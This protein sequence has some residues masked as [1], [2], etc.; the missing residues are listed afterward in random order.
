MCSKNF[1]I[2]G[3]NIFN[4]Y[5]LIWYFLII[6]TKFNL[7]Y[8]FTCHIIIFRIIICHISIWIMFDQRFF[9]RCIPWHSICLGYI[10]INSLSIFLIIIWHSKREIKCILFITFI[11]SQFIQIII[12]LIQCEWIQSDIL[13]YVLFPFILDIMIVNPLT[14]VVT[15]IVIIILR[16]K[17][18]VNECAFRG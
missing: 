4:Y 5:V 11:Q 17:W 6:T 7:I 14:R 3:F 9:L 10:Q 12:V 15:V 8:S 18:V 13:A 2:F 1:F 16:F